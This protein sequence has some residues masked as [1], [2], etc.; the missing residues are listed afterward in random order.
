MYR[1]LII[2]ALFIVS[3]AYGQVKFHIGGRANIGASWFGIKE[4]D[5][6][7]TYQWT[8][9]GSGLFFQGGLVTSIEINKNW[10]I[11]PE[12]LFSQQSGSYTI[13][14][15]TVKTDPS[16]NPTGEQHDYMFFSRVNI[17][18]I[19]IPLQIK[20]RSNRLY[21]M[22][23][24]SYSIGLEN[25]REYKRQGSD[26]TATK[27]FNRD[28]ISLSNSIGV[29]ISKKASIDLKIHTGLRPI[30]DYG[31][32]IRGFCLGTTMLF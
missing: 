4:V 5:N 12:V 20:L 16:G 14:S 11:Q 17:N 10:S 31:Y 30:D 13:M 25:K 2:V 24:V 23:G 1:I 7:S 6:G 28:D 8:D 32:K 26:Y 19:H 29:F 21:I 18:Q 22:T 9:G 27:N 15:T 3:D